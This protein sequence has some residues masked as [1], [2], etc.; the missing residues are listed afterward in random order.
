MR[1]PAWTRRPPE[2]L[3]CGGRGPAIGRPR[4]RA[5]GYSM[6]KAWI[7]SVLALRDGA[8]NFPGV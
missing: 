5:V 3:P 6:T 8:E 4:L 7:V 2:K 1:S